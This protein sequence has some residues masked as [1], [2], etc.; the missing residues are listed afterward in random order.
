[1]R[2]A[3]SY[4]AGGR[5]AKYAPTAPEEENS[6]ISQLMGY[7]GTALSTV[8]NILDYPG[9][10]V[11][12]GLSDITDLL[13]GNTFEN[14]AVES[15]NPYQWD[16]RT[17]GRNLLEQWGLA[18]DNDMGWMPDAGDVAGF[19]LELATDPLSY[20]TLGATT[21][22][23][24]AAQMSGK[25]TKGLLPG[26]KAG[27]R[28]LVGVGLP[29]RSP[30][31][32]IGGQGSQVGEAIAGGMDKAFDAARFG[33]VKDLTG[34]VVN[35]E[36]SPGQWLE[37]LFSPID[38]KTPEVGRAARV[39]AQAINGLPVDAASPVATGL[40]E[41]WD[42]GDFDI[43]SLFSKHAKEMADANLPEDQLSALS[44]YK[45]GLL[46][47]RD[48]TPEYDSNGTPLWGHLAQAESLL[49]PEARGLAQRQAEESKT[50]M[51][52]IMAMKRDAGLDTGNNIT[53]GR[54][55]YVH[56]QMVDMPGETG[57][58]GRQSQLEDIAGGTGLL[59]DRIRGIAS[60][61]A[62]M[63]DEEL[64]K[65]F[66]TYKPDEHYGLVE[67]ILND[68]NIGRA[69]SGHDAAEYVLDKYYNKLVGAAEEAAWVAAP[70][71]EILN[72]LTG[73]GKRIEDTYMNP[74]TAGTGQ[75][76]LKALR[77]EAKD[78]KLPVFG[79]EGL[80]THVRESL[81]LEKSNILNKYTKSQTDVGG[82]GRD[83]LVDVEQGLLAD[84]HR[85]TAAKFAQEVLGKHAK[86]ADVAKLSDPRR[87]GDAMEML[88]FKEGDDAIIRFLKEVGKHVPASVLGD[89][90]VADLVV[91][92][93]M[94]RDLQNMMGKSS[95]TEAD[96]AITAVLDPLMNLFKAGTLVW[97]GRWP[98]DLAEGMITNAAAG[99]ASAGSVLDTTDILFGGKAPRNWKE[100]VSNPHIQ[101]E[102]AARKLEATPENVNGILQELI[103]STDLVN[104]RQ[105]V[106]G[107]GAAVGK[108]AA[109]TPARSSDVLEEV[110]GQKP[111]TIGD[112]T[113]R[114]SSWNPL[115]QRGLPKGLTTG[116]VNLR[117]GFKPTAAGEKLGQYSDEINR[118]VPFFDMLK[119]GYDP[120][121]A[122]K[123]VD[124]LQVNY[125]PE[126]FSK[127]ERNVLK[128]AFPFYSF[129]RK[130]VPQFTK[131]LAEKP[132]GALGQ[133]IRMERLQEEGGRGDPN[134][135]VAQG[136]GLAI[137]I[138]FTDQVIQGIGN[139][140]SVINQTFASPAEGVSGALRKLGAQ[141]RPEIKVPIE[142]AT[143]TQMYF[144][145]PTTEQYNNPI[146]GATTLNA[147]LQNAAP[148]YTTLARR[149]T[150]SDPA[151][152][153]LKSLTG[154][155]WDS[156]TEDATQNRERDFQRLKEKY[157]EEQPGF[158]KMEKV[159]PVLP[160]GAAPEDVLAPEILDLLRAGQTIE[161]RGRKARRQRVKE[162]PN[163]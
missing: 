63:T 30:A 66:P 25:A 20:L 161:N 44:D 2:V 85:I 17:T 19:G 29:F 125:R 115:A 8:G 59:R 109:V 27:E 104:Q 144:N 5:Q 106:Y 91:D 98:R 113:S 38:A 159:Y 107:T 147:I 80:P 110:L 89:R 23:G 151:S 143:G 162:Q 102:L 129:T 34:R 132:G 103:R 51:N 130:Y 10:F 127:F 64:T 105:G 77:G 88:G 150:S 163:Y 33:K 43:R 53:P 6:I 145:E 87:L 68:P 18:G 74:A 114:G 158:R 131:M 122:R 116:E 16:E 78:V 155:G 135:Y 70:N 82:F 81:R 95:L 58:I 152:G 120:L 69:A 49:S 41:A 1:M 108:M 3:P 61:G 37:S 45:R 60:S 46:E 139:P 118:M 119:E 101:S 154:M 9:A 14:K 117:T 65:A 123:R 62:D 156:T 28:A 93:A 100:Y 121:V 128:R 142:L 35:W 112:I 4:Y 140:T 55:N 72:A 31:N 26:I 48:W 90:R 96:N 126:S 137:P 99:H 54:Y 36:A 76:F 11:R 56:R 71:Q 13:Q 47:K 111:F 157:L 134:H 148:R 40:Q 52:Q 86:P 146:P 15:L 73:I 67:T 136:N 12:G 153:L 79:V 75:D 57:S 160:D 124:A 141:L 84:Q 97:P 94:V 92:D 50:L 7:G 83:T 138:P 42:A 32:F 133:M 24:K 22:A 39:G 149:L 21:A